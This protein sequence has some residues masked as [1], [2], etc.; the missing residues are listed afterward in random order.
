[1]DLAPGTKADADAIALGDLNVAALGFMRATLACGGRPDLQAGTVV[2]IEGAGTRF[3]GP[4]YVTSVT[5]VLDADTG[6]STT[7]TAE[8][9][10]A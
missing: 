4:Y 8:R 5:H 1:M 3:S 10:G 6:Y 2:R 7:L 9:S